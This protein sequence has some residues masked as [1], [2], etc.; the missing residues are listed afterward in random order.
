MLHWLL[1]ISRTD[2]DLERFPV[3]HGPV[4]VRH[5]FEADGTVEHATG[6]ECAFS[7]VPGYETPAP[8]QVTITGGSTTVANGA[9]TSPPPSPATEPR[10]T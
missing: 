8:Q 1:L 5:I 6:L 7:D 2:E 10:P 4:G 3:R 9:F